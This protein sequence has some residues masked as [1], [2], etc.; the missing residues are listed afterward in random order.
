MASK[1]V[2]SVLSGT[3]YFGTIM[4]AVNQLSGKMHLTDALGADSLGLTAVALLFFA[5][6]FLGLVITVDDYA[7]FL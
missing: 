4:L 1:I 3:G 6:A 2:K 7:D 5:T